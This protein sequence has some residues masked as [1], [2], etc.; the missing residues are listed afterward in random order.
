MLYKN[1]LYEWLENYIKPSSKTRTYERYKQIVNMHIVSKIGDYELNDITPALLQNLVAELLNNGN[2]RTFTGLS[3]NSVNSVISVL[4]N[5]LKTAN[6]LCYTKTYV[7]GKIIRPRITEKQVECFSLVEQKK[8]ETYCLQSKKKKLYG[9]VICLYTGLRIGELLALK[10]SD[11]D[12]NKS[13]MYISKTCHD[14]LNGRIIETPKTN[15]SN[16]IIPLPRQI[17]GL[18]KELKREAYSEYLIADLDKPVAV[19]SYQRTF[20][21]LLKK[22]NIQ[23]KGF[24][25][26]RHTFATRALECGMDVK[27]LSELLGHKNTSITLNRYVHS[28]LEHKT[29]MMNKLAKTLTKMSTE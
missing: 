12:F 21:L 28:M 6:M 27:T 1:W 15:S 29:D 23:H 10:F 20:E 25:S 14:S 4:Q 19:R 17:L 7:A 11:I 18:I 5:S 9:I 3:A 16:R 2:K 13:I 22:L 26:L 24:H 8:I